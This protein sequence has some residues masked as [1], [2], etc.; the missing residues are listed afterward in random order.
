[1]KKNYK[2]II[3]QLLSK[4]KDLDYK[5]RTIENYKVIYNRFLAYSEDSDSLSLSEDCVAFLKQQYHVSEFE[6]PNKTQQSVIRAINLLI[7]FKRSGIFTIRMKSKDKLAELIDDSFLDLYKKFVAY[8]VKEFQ[9]SES[10]VKSY[11]KNLSIVPQFISTYHQEV[12]RNKLRNYSLI[13]H[14]GKMNTFSEVVL[15]DI[16][17]GEHFLIIFIKQS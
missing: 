3:D 11:K 12:S 15:I 8:K 5:E 4:F 7:D 17:R 2:E 14:I 1:M 10:T 9:I 6:C 13:N 16:I